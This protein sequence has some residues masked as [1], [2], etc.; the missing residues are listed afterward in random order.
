MPSNMK[1]FTYGDASMPPHIAALMDNSGRR[2]PQ[3][4]VLVAALS[5]VDAQRMLADRKVVS[6]SI[7]DREFRVARGDDVDALRAADA[8]TEPSIYVVPGVASR[9]EKVVRIMENGAPERVG[10]LVR[11]QGADMEFIPLETALPFA[12]HADREA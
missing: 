12:D 2:M 4:V 7:H 8:F 11:G 10:R 9:G 3:A 6:I 1:V 5:K